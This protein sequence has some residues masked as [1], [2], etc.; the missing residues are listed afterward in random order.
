MKEFI[1]PITASCSQ[2]KS[3]SHQELPPAHNE[4]VYRIQNCPLLTKKEFIAS[5]T[6]SCSPWKSLSHPELPPA[7]CNA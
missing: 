7:C 5:R 3:L 6:A 4:R 2:W 1:T